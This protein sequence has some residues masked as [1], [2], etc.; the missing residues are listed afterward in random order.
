MRIVTKDGGSVEVLLADVSLYLKVFERD[1]NS[2]ASEVHSEIG[3]VSSRY[4]KNLR[5]TK[6][7]LVIRSLDVQEEEM[8]V[9]NVIASTN[10]DMPS[11]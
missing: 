6:S 4:Q 9:D 8:D 3:N 1:Q 10:I 2:Q 5:R 11:N 7:V